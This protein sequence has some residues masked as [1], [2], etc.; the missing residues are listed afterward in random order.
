MPIASRRSSKRAASTGK[1]PAKTTGCAGLKPG[2]RPCRRI[3]LVRHRVADAGVGHFLDGGGEEAD[4]AGAQ[5]VD[6]LALGPRYADPFDLVGPAGR[7]QLDPLALADLAIDD[8][9]QH[10]DAEIGI[11]PA[12]DEERLQR[13]VAVAL[14]RGQ[15]VDDRLQHIG[16]AEAGL[17]RDLDR[18]RGV[19]PDHVLDL[20]ADAFGLRGR[21]I[22][23]VE[24]GNDL[25]IVVDRLIDIG[26]RLGLD[27]LARIDDE[28]RTL[29]GGER[30]RHLIGEIDMAR[31]VDEVEHI[32]LARFRRV[33]EAHG[34][35]LDG[36]A[37]LALEVHRI[38][39]LV[40]HLPF[41]DGPAQLDQPV[42]QRRFAVIDMGDDGEIADMAKIGHSIS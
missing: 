2:K 20:L 30:A 8:A 12:V 37:A 25:V 13:R 16:H 1:K 27:P 39:D 29:A 24:D 14:G 36:D 4:L 7:H 33:V 19:E 38:E 42:G 31:R 3:L 21:Q 23:L 10:D 5:L 34:I 26:E 28:K 15:A 22:D 40:D 6:H 11:V 32:F 35:G 17:G 41:G 18:V 9:Q